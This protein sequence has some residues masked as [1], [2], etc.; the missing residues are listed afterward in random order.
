MELIKKGIILILLA[1]AGGLVIAY[2]ILSVLSVV[3]AA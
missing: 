1:G 3:N 2:T